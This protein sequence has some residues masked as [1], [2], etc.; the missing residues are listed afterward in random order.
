ML[1]KPALILASLVSSS[2][3]LA[4]SAYYD[5]NYNGICNQYTPNG[6]LIEYD[7]ERYHCE[8]NHPSHYAWN[9]DGKCNQYAPNG[10]LIE[11][12]VDHYHCEL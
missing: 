1:A 4:N 12:D 6:A 11:Y 8:L 5:W 3:V 9:D 7:A 2:V 10:A